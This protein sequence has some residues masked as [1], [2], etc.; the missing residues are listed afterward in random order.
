[1]SRDKILEVANYVAMGYPHDTPNEDPPV[2]G[3]FG[4]CREDPAVAWTVARLSRKYPESWILLTGG[5][6]K[7]SGA[8]SRELGSEAA[9][10]AH[11]LEVG[12]RVCAQRMY[13]EKLAGNGA[14]NSRNGIGVIR[15]RELAHRRIVLVLHPRN[16]R[17]V[18]A[19]HMKIAE[20]MNFT[21]KYQIVCTHNAFD[22]D[23]PEH[24]REVMKEL[25]RIADWPLTG[26]STPQVF[27]PTDLVECPHSNS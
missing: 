16:A 6:G 17:R 5:L 23:N 12:H 8:R 24:S 9:H 4:F 18:W 7:D 3:I 27:L 1:M 22:P 15:A 14:E 2:D 25:V 20:E 10:Q 11:M 26:W 19:T 21:A 13:L